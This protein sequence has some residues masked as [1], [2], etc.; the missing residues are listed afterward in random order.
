[1]KVPFSVH[2]SEWLLQLVAFLG[3]VAEPVSSTSGAQWAGLVTNH[4]D[5]VLAKV[6]VE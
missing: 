5:F 3:G 4:C 6:E 2:A 1:M